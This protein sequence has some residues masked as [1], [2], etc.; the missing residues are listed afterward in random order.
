MT[1]ELRYDPNCK[2]ATFVGPGGFT[3]QPMSEANASAI[4]LALGIP[5]RTEGQSNEHQEGAAATWTYL[6]DSGQ[7]ALARR[8]LDALGISYTDKPW[9]KGTRQ[10]VV[11]ASDPEKLSRVFA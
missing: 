8:G 2:L 6:V 4:A 10:F 11:D 3:Q 5:F 1:V 9:Q 7:A